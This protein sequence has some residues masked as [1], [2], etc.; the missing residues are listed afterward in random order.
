MIDEKD[1][2]GITISVFDEFEL[3]RLKLRFWV[4]FC[5]VRYCD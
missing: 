1:T 2:V 5:A 3:L 4:Y